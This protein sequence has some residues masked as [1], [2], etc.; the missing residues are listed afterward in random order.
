MVIGGGISGLA[1]AAELSLVP[2]VRVTVLEASPRLGGKLA[3]TEVGGVRIDTG[4]ESLL[5]TRPEAVDLVREAG[6]GDRV[7]HPATAKAWLWSRN[8]MHPMPTGLVMGAPSGF[9][10]VARG[11]VLSVPGVMSMAAGSLRRRSPMSSADIGSTSIGDYVAARVGREV[12]DRL[13]D[14]LLAG[15]YAGD[16]YA[17]DLQSVAPS[18]AKAATEHST[19]MGAASAARRSPSVPVFAGIDG[20]VG[21]LPAA[22]AATLESRGVW[23][24]KGSRVSALQRVGSQGWSVTVAPEFADGAQGSESIT[25]DAIILAVPAPIAA[26]LLAAHSPASAEALREIP[27]ASVAVVSFAYPA[28]QRSRL[29]D[30]S[31]FLVPSIDEHFIKASTFSSIKWAWTGRA[32][33]VERSD[34]LLMLRASVGRWRETASL[35]LSDAEIVAAA[36]ADLVTAVGLTAPPV[37]THVQRWNDSLPQ[38]LVGHGARVARVRAG[39]DDLTGLAVCGAA[40]DGVGIAACVASG[41][42]AARQALAQPLAS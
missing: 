35:Q 42:T 37:D 13:V 18:L 24:R 14:P 5:N 32:S 3:Q 29:P 36:H 9:A 7:V 40:L 30:G 1:A 10:S 17:L 31:G 15:V 19:L 39:L 38:Y 21:M 41:R 25:C 22:L 12:V 11:G 20:G 33:G 16:P 34:G 4:A 28:D 26:D 23:I 8:R 27:Y 6:L 2:G